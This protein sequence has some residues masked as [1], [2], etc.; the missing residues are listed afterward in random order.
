[1]SI[2]S[3]AVTTASNSAFG[4]DALCRNITEMKR[5]FIACDRG[6]SA[7][8]VEED[9]AFVKLLAA[10]RYGRVQLE[11]RLSLV[12]SN[13]LEHSQLL[14]VDPTALP[15]LT[16]ASG[17]R[18]ASTEAVELAQ[19]E[20]RLK[21]VTAE[22]ENRFELLQQLTRHA[23]Q[24]LLRSTLFSNQPIPFYLDERF[25]RD[26]ARKRRKP[27]PLEHSPRRGV[28]GVPPAGSS[29]YSFYHAAVNSHSPPGLLPPQRRRLPPMH[30][31]ST[32]SR[33]AS[34]AP[35]VDTSQALPSK[36][37]PEPLRRRRASSSRE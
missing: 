25:I 37:T 19:A 32:V 16:L 11:E 23:P 10:E 28:Q 2:A 35:G 33:S 20:H 1:M 24:R 31:S 22:A 29:G 6:V 14:T 36:S 17:V 5:V 12:F 7:L 15:H 13:S 8:Y 27:Q 9:R 18:F 4:F 3:S 30:G 26:V 21:V 34:A